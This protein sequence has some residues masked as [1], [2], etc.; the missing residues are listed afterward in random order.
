MEVGYELQTLFF[1]EKYCKFVAFSPP[2]YL[3]VI[4]SE[5]FTKKVEYQVVQNFKRFGDI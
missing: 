3:D 2:I 1:K 5:R 4:S